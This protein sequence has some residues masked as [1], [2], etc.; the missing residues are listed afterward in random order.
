MNEKLSIEYARKI[1]LSSNKKFSKYIKENIETHFN[2]YEELNNSKLQFFHALE[3]D[4]FL[5]LIV[6]GEDSIRKR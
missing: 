4:Y 6:K 5:I 3:L 2:K 1:K